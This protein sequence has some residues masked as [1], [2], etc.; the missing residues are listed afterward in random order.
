M[1]GK[2]LRPLIPACLH[3]KLFQAIPGFGS[4]LSFHQPSSPLRG[5]L[6][7]HPM[8]SEHLGLLHGLKTAADEAGVSFRPG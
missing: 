1:R 3:R 6:R 7:L 8:N 4:D 2:A 5:D